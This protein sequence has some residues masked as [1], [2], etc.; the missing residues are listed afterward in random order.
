MKINTKEMIKVA[1]FFSKMHKKGGEVDMRVTHSRAE[2]NNCGTPACI[3]GWLSVYYNTYQNPNSLTRRYSH[4]AN[5]FAKI[6]GF[7]YMK[8]LCDWA[9]EN[10]TLWGENGD[11][12]INIILWGF[13]PCLISI[14]K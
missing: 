13:Y 3:G 5:I 10:K 11:L 14:L 6:I 1:N 9:E 12:C 8:H 2:I 7:D 4:G